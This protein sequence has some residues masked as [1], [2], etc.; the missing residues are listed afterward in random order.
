MHLKFWARTAK[1]DLGDVSLHANKRCT[2]EIHHQSDGK[3]HE[4]KNLR[5]DEFGG[6]E[7][8]YVLPADARLGQYYVHLKGDV[9]GGSVQFRVEEYKKPEFEVTIKAPTKPVRLGEE[10]E[11]EVIATYYHG[12]PVS[13]GTVKVKVQR[14]SHTERWFPRGQWDWLYGEGYWWFGRD[15]GWDGGA[16]LHRSWFWSGSIRSERMEE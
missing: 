14:Y 6:V 13:E 2:V 1:Y 11:A 10:I 3:V 4:V 15:Y 7:L 9:P 12:A 8:D 16:G 5:T